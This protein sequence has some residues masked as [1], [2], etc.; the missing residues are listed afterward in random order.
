MTKSYINLTAEQVNA[1][2]DDKGI[3]YK[4][5]IRPQPQEASN[6]WFDWGWG[7]FGGVKSDIPKAVFW[8]GETAERQ[9]GT[10]PIDEYCPYGQVGDVLWVREKWATARMYDDVAPSQID[11]DASL[12]WFAD[13]SSLR[14]LGSREGKA[15]SSTH[16]PRW[17]SRL[18]VIIASIKAVQGASGWEWVLELKLQAR[19]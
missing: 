9:I 15:R 2:L 7:K 17:A 12:W 3:E 11:N 1:L 14:H 18:D 4:E 13:K 19:R 16:M 10:A 5:L 8:H 6:G